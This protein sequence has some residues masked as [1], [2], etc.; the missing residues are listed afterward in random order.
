MISLNHILW[1]MI[2]FK[3]LLVSVLIVATQCC[4]FSNK[5]DRDIQSDYGSTVAKPGQFPYV[6]SLRNAANQIFCSGT[7]ISPNYVLTAG[8]CTI[9]ARR[10]AEH[11]HVFAGSRTIHDGELH[12]VAEI[13]RHPRFTPNFFFFDVALLR[14]TT[15]VSE[16]QGRIRFGRLPSEDLLDGD[17]LIGHL[18]G[19]G[20]SQ[21]E[22]MRF[23]RLSPLSIKC[24]YWQLTIDTK[25]NNTNNSTNDSMKFIDFETIDRDVCR[26]LLGR[27]AIRVH[28]HSVCGLSL[29]APGSCRSEA[30]AGAPLSSE[31]G[32]IVGISSFSGDCRSR[33]PNVFVRVFAVLDFIR[34]YISQGWAVDTTMHGKLHT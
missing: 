11:I 14:L 32:L 2:S 28:E 7:I 8:R 29:A 5:T 9:G 24:F 30:D 20:H 1:K 25:H 13:I 21:V 18:A 17:R 15:N 3:L 4:F 33:R 6:V 23:H 22:T 26:E 10:Q 31:D 19:W 27:S 12:R 16:D 34:Q